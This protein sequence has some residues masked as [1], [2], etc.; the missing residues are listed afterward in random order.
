MLPDVGCVRTPEGD[1][2]F[3]SFGV[4]KYR[5]GADTLRLKGFSIPI[6]QTD[7]VE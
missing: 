3:V 5:L 7:Y 4:I 1:R 6:E 2:W